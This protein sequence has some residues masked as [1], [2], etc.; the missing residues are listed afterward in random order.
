MQFELGGPRSET[1]VR[2]S[3]VDVVAPNWSADGVYSS[4][5]WSPDGRRIA[6]LVTFDLSNSEIRVIERGAERARTVTRTSQVRGLGWLPDGS[7]LV[8]ASAE[9]STLVYPPIF[10]LRRVAL[11]GSDD[12]SL[13]IAGAG[14][15]SWVD[16]D[17][18]PDGTL[19]ASRVGLDSDVYRVPVVGTP[20]ENV[21]NAVRIT[22][23]T[24]QVQVPT[25]SPDGEE[26][27][28]LSDSGGHANVWVAR[29]DRSV[30]PRPITAEDDPDVVIGLPVWS[31][32]GDLIVYYRQRT[33]EVATLRLIRPDGTGE[34]R[35]TETAGGASW[36]RDG[37]WVYH[38]SPSGA[39]RVTRRTERI[40]VDGG[41][42]L[43]VRDGAAGILLSSDGRTGYFSPSTARQG[44][45]WR[46]SPVATGVAELLIGDLQSRL[47]LWPHHYHLS[48][49]DR[50]LATP[51]ADGG[52]TNLWIVST[53]DGSLRRITDYG[54]RAILIGRQ[55]SW[56]NDDRA[57]FAAVLEMDA[58]V[59]QLEGVLP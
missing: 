28:Y 30:P 44:E 25:A 46:A 4:P 39:G 29:V 56:S 13:P 23:Q 58:D 26:V 12:R 11:D 6:F 16:P 3:R 40:R 53:A 17:L 36:S 8:Y 41:D 38:M 49:D 31:P 20:V 7:G 35:L 24:G 52:T 45:V 48:S 42:P 18:A 54:E 22:E 19:V 2:L 34:R 21:R 5:R 43:P 14:Y 15:V 50:W 57:I 10:S 33:G 32:R 37:N 51:L 9:G 47:P 55:V 59:V 27:A 1:V